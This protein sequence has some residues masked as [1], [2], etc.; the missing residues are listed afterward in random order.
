MHLF[1]M[2]NCLCSLIAVKLLGVNL[3]LPEAIDDF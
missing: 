1:G 2:F 3:R